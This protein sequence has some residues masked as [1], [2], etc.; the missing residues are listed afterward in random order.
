MDI[1]LMILK[2]GMIAFAIGVGVV[3]AYLVYAGAT[4]VIMGK[5]AGGA[6]LGQAWREIWWEVRPGFLKSAKPPVRKTPWGR[7]IQP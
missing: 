4:L 7:D 6:S 3:V 5:R 2:W 1:V